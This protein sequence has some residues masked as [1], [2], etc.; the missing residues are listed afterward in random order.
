MKPVIAG[1]L[2]LIGLL[3]GA[4]IGAILRP[5]PPSGGDHAGKAANGDGT[6][7]GADHE[8]DG[9]A[10][11]EQTDY[12]TLGR[13]MIVP[14][15]DGETTVA[16]MVFE[17]A[18]DLPTEERER[19]LVREPLIRD[20]FLRDL[21]EFSYTG[22]FRRSYIE[23]ALVAE[24]KEKLLATAR[25]HVSSRVREVLILDLLRKEV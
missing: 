25:L 6:G 2:V 24:I 18:L 4:A 15:L 21:F 10:E 23:D 14:V 7:I 16:F 3:G 5:P 12:V 22:A 8:T 13:Q 11:E 1:L 20:A 17:F 9:Q 19:A